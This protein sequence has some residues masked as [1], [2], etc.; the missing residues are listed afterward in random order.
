[1]QTADSLEGCQV[2]TM[3]CRHI[4]PSLEED[5]SQLI[6]TGEGLARP[7]SSQAPSIK[8]LQIAHNGGSNGLLLVKSGIWGRRPWPLVRQVV[9]L[10][11][12]RM[13]Q[14]IFRLAFKMMAMISSPEWPV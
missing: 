12:L 2:R 10:G 1:M 11:F 9:Y 13:R 14:I 4:G 7:V 3:T 5:G 6:E 8:K